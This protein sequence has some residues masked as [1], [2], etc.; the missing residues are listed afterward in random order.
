MLLQQSAKVVPDWQGQGSSAMALRQ[1][2]RNRFPLPHSHAA[3]WETGCREPVN[4]VGHYIQ[5]GSPQACTR[6]AQPAAPGAG[7]YVTVTLSTPNEWP[8]VVSMSRVLSSARR[9]RSLAAAADSSR[10]PASA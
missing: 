10:S 9:C 4:A 3:A 2:S 5:R 6:S 7:S 1:Q 8:R